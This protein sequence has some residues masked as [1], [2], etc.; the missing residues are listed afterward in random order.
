MKIQVQLAAD[1]LIDYYFFCKAIAEGIYPTDLKGIDCIVGKQTPVSVSSVTPLYQENRASFSESLRSVVLIGGANFKDQPSPNQT[2]GAESFIHPL[3][4]LG[5]CEEAE[6]FSFPYKL[7]D[8]DRTLIEKLLPDLPALHFPFTEQDATKFMNAYSAHPNRPAWKPLLVTAAHVEKLKVEQ[9][10]T[11]ILHQKVLLEELAL[12]RLT[13]VNANH[14]PAKTLAPGVFIPRKEAISYLNRCGIS[15]DDSE[16][17]EIPFSE[18]QK[19]VTKKKQVGKR[20]VDEKDYFKLVEYR[21]ALIAKNVKNYSQLTGEKFN[22]N[23]RQ[24]LN[25]AKAYEKQTK[26]E[27]NAKEFWVPPPVD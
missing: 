22:I 25:I 10:K 18:N 1:Q 21:N 4:S 14:I 27:K 16:I 20:K 5:Q 7:L 9:H 23:P 24:V 2:G 3:P 13:A 6:E 26:N 11:M 8:E 15:H 17:N 12:G 19:A